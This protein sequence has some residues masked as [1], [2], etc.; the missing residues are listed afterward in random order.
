MIRLHN[1]TYSIICWGRIWFSS[2]RISIKKNDA[3]LWPIQAVFNWTGHML[4]STGNLNQNGLGGMFHNLWIYSNREKERN[5]SDK[6]DY[7]KTN[8]ITYKY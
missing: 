1:I 6:K 5:K 2:R 3:D 7:K 4:L 8:D